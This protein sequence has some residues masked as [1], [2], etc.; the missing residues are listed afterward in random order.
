MTQT[1]AGKLIGLS[2]NA[3]FK[4]QHGTLPEPKHLVALAV[5]LEVA[6]EWLES[7]RGPKYCAAPEDLLTAEI[8]KAVTRLEETQ[9]MELL[10]YA[11]Y[12]AGDV[13]QA[14]TA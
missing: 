10:R 6:R 13:R 2:Q 8:F 3:G 4:W 1:K 7:G 12:I 11:Q 14:T 5:K 9:R